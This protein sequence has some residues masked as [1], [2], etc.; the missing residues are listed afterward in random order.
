MKNKKKYLQIQQFLRRSFRP[1][2]RHGGATALGRRKSRRPLSC[3]RPLQVVLSA[4]R[5]PTRLGLSSKQNAAWAR[6]II[7]RQSR[8]FGV[9]VASYSLID[10]ELHLICRISSRVGF[11]NFLRSSTA[12]IARKLTG[13]RKGKSFGKFWDGLALTQIFRAEFFGYD[14]RLA[15]AG[16]CSWPLFFHQAL[17]LTNFSSA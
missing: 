6:T 15:F 5:V 9:K 8:K 10:N 7:G 14:G 3:R 4:A 12:L 13:A 16:R 1:G 11:Q 2:S 17:A